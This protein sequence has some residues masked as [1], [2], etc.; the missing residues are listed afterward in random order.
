MELHHSHGWAHLSLGDLGRMARMRKPHPYLSLRLMASLAGQ[1]PGE[2]L[3]PQ[4]IDA[5]LNQ[6]QVLR[7]RSPVI[8]DG[9]PSEP[10]HVTKLP[11]GAKL[12]CL[13]VPEDV[14][15][16]RLEFRTQTTARRWNPDMGPGLR[17]HQL[18]FLLQEHASR[19]VKVSAA[20]HIEDI[21]RNVL[22]IAIR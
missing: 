21:A 8:V 16:E 5:L 4:V 10:Y 7:E 11:S 19:V 17:D 9:F 15:L 6:V 13:E 1:I 20:G 14:R 2:R 22:S 3:R 12:M 18:P